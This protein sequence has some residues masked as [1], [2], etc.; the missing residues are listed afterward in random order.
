[1]QI[2]VVI[3]YSLRMFMGLSA[4]GINRQ[5]SFCLESANQCKESKLQCLAIPRL[6]I[7][8]LASK[9]PDEEC[10]NENSRDDEFEYL[11]STMAIARGILPSLR[12]V[13]SLE[14]GMSCGEEGMVEAVPDSCVNTLNTKGYID[15]HGSDFHCIICKFELCNLYYRCMGCDVLMDKDYNICVRCYKDKSYLDEMDMGFGKGRETSLI[16]RK[17]K[18]QFHTSK[19]ETPQCGAQK[20]KRTLCHECEQCWECSCMC[21]RKFTEHR[22]FYTDHDL[23]NM[24]DKCVKYAK[25]KEVLYAKETE[26]RLD[27]K[28][29][30]IDDKVKVKVPSRY[31]PNVIVHLRRN[32]EWKIK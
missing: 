7:L 16:V 8:K 23:Q 18:N 5:L 21:H 17:P 9:I 4:E 11:P 24:L 32:G 13:L 26:M 6:A 2:D 10:E 19:K 22:R 1:M 30:R 12:H 25:G 20:C 15:P 28:K 3:N 14:L 31:Y 27:G 29:M